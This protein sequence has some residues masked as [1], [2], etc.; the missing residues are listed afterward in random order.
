MKTLFNDNWF[1]SKQPGGTEYSEQLLST[2]DWQPVDIPH[3]WMIY[4]TNNLYT[5]SVGFYK[6]TFTMENPGLSLYSLLFDGVYMDSSVY[7]NGKLAGIWR[8]GY[9]SFI[10]DITELITAG[11]NTVVVRVNYQEPNTRW[12]SGAGIFRDVKLVQTESL[13]ILHN[14]IYLTAKPEDAT[15]TAENPGFWELTA[16]IELVNESA[17]TE[18]TDAYIRNEV[19]DADGHPVA[20]FDGTVSVKPMA[21]TPYAE[22]SVCPEKFATVFKATVSIDEP[23]LWSL[24]DPYCYTVRTM[25]M[26]NGVLADF[27]STTLGFRTILADS[28]KGFFLNNKHVKLNGAC[29]H[30]D[31]GSLGAAFNVVAAERQFKSLKAMGINSIR[32]SHNPAAEE[33]IRLADRFGMLID[34]EFTDM[35]ERKKTENDYGNYFHDWCE[36]D[37]ASWLRRDRNHPS[38]IMWSTGNEI[39]DT[40]FENEGVPIVKRLV[41]FIRFHDPDCH[42]LSTIGSNF[43]ESEGAQKVATYLDVSGYNYTERLYEGHHAAHPEW[44]IYGSETASTVQSRGIY[45]FPASRR[46]LTHD[47][48]QCSSLEN[49][50]TNW[51]AKTPT[52]VVCMDRD[53]K[54]SLGQ[55]IWTGWDYIGEPTPYHT[56]NSYFGQADTAG[57]EKDSYYIYQAGWTDYKT[58]P[59]IHL[60]P[61]WDFNEGQ[62]ID[63]RAYSNAPK[64]E[65]FFNDVSQGT[66]E[67]DHE[68][69]QLFSGE[70]QLPYAKG[71]LKAV[72]YDENGAIIAT[73]ICK[74]FGDT[75]KLQLIADKTELK[76]NGED[77][78]FVEIRA[79][80]EAGTFVANAR[81]RVEVTV[82]GAGRL[83]GLD[84]GD[85]T[86][87]DQYKGTSRKLFSGRLLAIIAAKKEA[88]EIDITV[89][90]P[91]LP[92]ETLK[93][94]AV[95]SKV[96]PGV[97]CLTENTKSAN[98][99]EIPI[100]KIEL[101]AEASHILTKEVPEI[102]VTAS[103]YPAN[104]SCKD[105]VWKA[106]NESGIEANFIKI[107]A[108]GTSA[109][110][111]AVGDG[112]FRLCCYAY[113]GKENPEVVSEYE[114]TAEGIGTAGLD[115]YELVCS[116]LRSCE[117]NN[118]EL[119]LSFQG[120]IF[121]QDNRS[122]VQFDN[123]EFG[124]YGSDEITIPIF[125]W[126]PT[127]KLEIWEGNP[128]QGG[129]LLLACTYE[130]E[131]VY[132]VYSTNTFK[133][134]KRLRGTKTIS[135]VTF[136]RISLQGF[137]FTRYEKAFCEIPAGECSLVTGDAFNHTEEEI[138]NIGNN[139]TIEFK[140]MNFGEK[141]AS[142]FIICGKT[143]NNVNAVHL[144]FR[145]PE[146]ETK[147]MVEFAHAET[148]EYQ[149]FDITPVYGSCTLAIIFLPG[150]NFDLK[151]IRFE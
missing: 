43:I 15:A 28:N 133:L 111:K 94:N 123:V 77:L 85:S 25:V 128:D 11:E 52:S 78:I 87:Y 96:R 65:L 16:S 142:K 3:D 81:N 147:Q 19:L 115:A 60:L 53:A 33:F 127:V 29:M 88:G 99:T 95:A 76:A 31:L 120:G 67:I 42:A 17:S 108:D 63:I 112:E 122:W 132:N 5:T 91:A 20:I 36:R 58:A 8:Y 141:G 145:T 89:T 40:F 143:L 125:H 44:V 56:K 9:T 151:S 116:C 57:F 14:G 134:P 118:A 137:Y 41:G 68:N 47:D 140:S 97:S 82:S 121:T 84:N 103:I 18:A 7:V 110:V 135:I 117:S 72:A 131:S 62:T 64:T 10:F 119:N 104:A 55:Y 114:F 146:G 59:M 100:R 130:H 144:Y 70:W 50:S 150:T 48:L 66:F 129:E 61:Y 46:L 148:Y 2:M 83:I 86:D 90:S 149:T 71:I 98:Q 51:G 136:A 27:E 69:G 80:D 139:V 49:C 37:C 101:H 105:I 138:T 35:W 21:P 13:H 12:Y 45:H 6:K 54:F 102:E 23:H 39:Y 30:H 73:D 109:K 75:A 106:L 24:E 26:V 113:N 93:L 79:V 74:S 1:F 92:T 107:T 22:V 34:S 124:D 32:T 126:D 38:I 4:D